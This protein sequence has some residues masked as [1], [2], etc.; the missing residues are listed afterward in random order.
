MSCFSIDHF[1][2]YGDMHFLHRI[3]NHDIFDKTA[4][5]YSKEVLS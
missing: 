1:D 2:R 5:T 4:E 3:K